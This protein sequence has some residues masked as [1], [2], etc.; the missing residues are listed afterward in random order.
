MTAS[1][2]LLGAG[3]ILVLAVACE[4]LASR[5]RVPPVIILLPVGFTAGALTSDANPRLLLGH[6]FQPLLELAVAV[7]L[8]AT[9][10]NLNLRHLTGHTRRIM[11]RLIGI[12]VP[13]TLA[14]GAAAAELLLG[15]SPGAAVMTGAILVIS[16]PTVVGS[17][18]AF[19]R[20]AE[21]LRNVLSA[22]G[23][24]ISPVGAVLGTVVFYGVQAS[25]H[26]GAGAQVGQFALSIGVGA[27]AGIIGTAVL[28]LLLC[29][30]TLP[31]TLGTSVQLAVVVGVAAGSDVL[32]A[33]TG[34]IA[35]V[36]MGLTLA[37]L[38]RFDVPARRP[39]LE[40]P[41]Q[42]LLGVLLLSVTATV[43]PQSLRHLVLPTL[44]LVAVLVLVAR[45][46]VA[47]VATR[48]SDLTRRE[49][50]FV[51]WLAPRGTVAAVTA[52]VFAGPLMA[53][54]VAG[55]AK[56]LPVT[57]LVIVMTVTLY[58]LTAALAA[59]W[60]G[61]LRSP[62]SRP[63]L[64]GG[65]DWVIDLGRTLQTAGLDVLMW[66]GLER[67]REQIKEAALPLAPSELLVSAT[68]DRA[69]LAGITTVL[70]LTAE[71][72][73]NALASAVLRYSVGDSVF[74][75]GP[76]AGG[77][78]VVA[79]FTGGDVLFGHAL[80]RST[81]RSRYQEGSRIVAL[82]AGCGDLPAGHE[83][84]FLVRA[85]GRLDPVT[86]QRTPA[87]HEG[88]TVVLLSTAES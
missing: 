3:L 47:L 27:A 14:L 86:R 13:T 62:R 44:G 54:G 53:G 52:A 2:I 10:L 59:R 42:L 81:M 38:R 75:L 29:K 12:G 28:W 5:L 56:I 24:L 49:R 32:H 19:V 78:G 60:L 79:P 83:L 35:A 48:R 76:P 88:D 30:L 64:V 23:T 39:F 8:Y 46:L 67:Q 34:L 7:I 84:L 82:Q 25:T 74:R 1:Q 16:G 72:D 31:E 57:F 87:A 80:N 65:E 70:L 63:L 69:E 26:H 17:L 11:L 43:T 33:D 71:D 66:A 55:A 4:V 22:E 85:D 20:P 37:N 36:I 77:R 50:F 41:V 61:V 68:A 45:P 6:A 21:R 15:M 40:T 58:G 73:F 9:G 18:L 51:G